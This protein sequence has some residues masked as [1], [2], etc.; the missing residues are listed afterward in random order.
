MLYVL[1]LSCYKT[2]VL[3][4]KFVIFDGIYEILMKIL[5]VQFII[6]YVIDL[7]KAINTTIHNIALYSHE[8]IPNL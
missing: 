5:L 7:A 3:N 6:H 8:P 2:I 4:S 1:S